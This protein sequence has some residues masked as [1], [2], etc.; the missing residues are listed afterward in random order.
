MEME[1][2]GGHYLVSCTP[3]LDEDGNIRKVI[4]IATDITERKKVRGCASGK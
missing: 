2:L 4:H 3:V 1:S